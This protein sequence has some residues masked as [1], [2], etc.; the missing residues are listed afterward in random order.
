MQ[1]LSV[2]E[3]KFSHKNST[4]LI[5][6]LADVPTIP[7]NIVQEIDTLLWSILWDA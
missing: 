7:N 5:G 4:T 1:F 6:F 3:E 2:K